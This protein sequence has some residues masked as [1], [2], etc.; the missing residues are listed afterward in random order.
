MQKCPICGENTI[1]DMSKL[2][3]G[4]ARSITCSKCGSKISIS[5][6]A[7]VAMLIF[8]IPLLNYMNSN[9]STIS[10]IIFLV[11]IIAYLFVHLKLV[12]LVVRHIGTKQI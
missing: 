8:M 1:S 7:L 11:S 3:L 12:P 2:S 9:E 6:W 5:W 4:P 10:L